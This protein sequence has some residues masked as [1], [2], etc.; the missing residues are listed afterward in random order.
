MFY[1]TFTDYH[2]FYFSCRPGD[3][4][5]LAIMYYTNYNAR[6]VGRAAIIR[7]N[8]L[9]QEMNSNS[10]PPRHRIRFENIV[11][12]PMISLDKEKNIFP[13]RLRLPKEKK[14]WAAHYIVNHAK[15]ECINW[16]CSIDSVLRAHRNAGVQAPFYSVLFCVK[17]FRLSRVHESPR[18]TALCQCTLHLRFPECIAEK[19]SFFPRK[20]KGTQ[21]ECNLDARFYVFTLN[22]LLHVQIWLH[23]Y[24]LFIRYTP[25]L[26]AHS[27]TVRVHF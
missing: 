3:A 1:F 13:S 17:C 25:Y 22:L 11:L 14:T 5:E 18:E 4:I 27:N 20:K 7:R 21:T 6:A 10:Y 2:L 26:L 16:R 8:D 19:L 12:S 23:T 24:R 9:D 15:S